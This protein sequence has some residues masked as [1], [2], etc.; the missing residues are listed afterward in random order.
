MA[1]NLDEGSSGSEVHP[2]PAPPARR[3]APTRGERGGD[4]SARVLEEPGLIF[5]SRLNPGE[6]LDPHAGAIDGG[7]AVRWSES[8]LAVGAEGSETKPMK[9]LEVV[10]VRTDTNDLAHLTRFGPASTQGRVVD[11]DEDLGVAHRPGTSARRSSFG[12]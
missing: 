9:G 8:T 6:R 11:Q 2:E 1:A 7:R 12:A 4:G 5:R 3:A 10:V